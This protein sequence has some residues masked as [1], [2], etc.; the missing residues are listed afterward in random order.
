MRNG[1]KA[2]PTIKPYDGPAGGYGSLE[3]VAEVLMREGLPLTGIDPLVHQN[4]PDG[5]MCVS[6]AWAK[7]AVPHPA[8][9]CENGAK[10][11]A[12]EITTKKTDES[13]CA[14]TTSG[15]TPWPLSQRAAAALA[16]SGAKRASCTWMLPPDHPEAIPG[17]CETAPNAPLVGCGAKIRTPVRPWRSRGMKS[18]AE[19]SCVLSQAI[20]VAAPGGVA[21]DAKKPFALP[22]KQPHMSLP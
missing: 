7:P 20:L 18:F 12:W 8:E 1:P 9:F 11:T 13:F 22:A 19:T 4:K 15:S 6:C 14:T 5:F 3:S 17:S 16:R 21:L 2:N 10:A